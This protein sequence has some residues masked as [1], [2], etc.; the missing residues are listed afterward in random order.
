[1]ENR[2]NYF[3]YTEKKKMKRKNVLPKKQIFSLK[4]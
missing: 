1:M 3:V 4:N 2:P